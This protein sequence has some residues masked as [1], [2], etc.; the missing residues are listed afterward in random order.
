V[1]A[2]YM[3]NQSLSVAKKWQPVDQCSAPCLCRRAKKAS[4]TATKRKRSTT[5]STK[6]QE[7]QKK[8][9]LQPR[10][11]R[12]QGKLPTKKAFNESA[13]SS[14]DDIA[15]MSPNSASTCSS[16]EEEIIPISK[17]MQIRKAQQD[18]VASEATKADTEISTGIVTRRKQ[19][20]RTKGR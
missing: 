16:A 14:S 5:A 10:V 7:A 1:L 18:Q 13:S 19:P 3:G 12:K 8:K 9:V 15:L 11:K 6:P 2:F 4:G 17:R 20:K